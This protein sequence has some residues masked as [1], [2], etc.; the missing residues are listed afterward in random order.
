MPV[1]ITNNAVTTLASSVEAASTSIA[2]S[3]GTGVR[4]PTLTAGDW[5]PM[6]L[7]K[8]TGEREIIKVTGRNNDLLTVKRAQE[9]TQAL[10]FNAGDKAELRVTAAVFAEFSALVAQAQADAVAADKTDIAMIVMSGDNTPPTR[11]TWLK[12]NGQAVSRT[13]YASLFARIGT[14]WGAGN[15]STTFN[16]PDFRG[17]FPRGLDEGRGLDVGRALNNTVQAD[18][19]KSHTHV[20]SSNSTGAHT[21]PV[22][23]TTGS[24]GA[25][26]HDVRSYEYDETGNY[27]ADS[28]GRGAVRTAS[29]AALSAGAHTH[30]VTGT[31]ASNGAH[32]HTI[33]VNSEGGTE[34]RVKNIATLFWIRAL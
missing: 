13:T 10:E 19:N 28:S 2:I 23:G 30:S 17:V 29:G 18:Q 21:H 14:T 26:T 24:A 20:A 34:V 4:F 8:P 32:N 6:T 25:H 16:L 27:I 1:K 7:I 31:A 11:G 9:G 12:C 3:A 33:T 5:F 22:S 15:G